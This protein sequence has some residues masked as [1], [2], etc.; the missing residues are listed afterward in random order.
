MQKIL[1][2]RGDWLW[3]GA[4]TASAPFFIFPSRGSIWIFA[5]VLVLIIAR[6]A[7][8]R[9][10]FDRTPLDWSICILFLQVFATCFVVPEIG[11][12]VPKVTGALYGVLYY[13]ALVKVIDSEKAL[14]TALS[15]YLAL[16]VG[17]A[18]IGFLGMIWYNEPRLA[19]ATAQ[20]PNNSPFV[21]WNLPGAEAGFNPNPLGGI[22]L[23]IVPLAAI[24]WIQPGKNKGR[25]VRP[26]GGL[27]RSCDCDL[28]HEIVWSMALAFTRAGICG[29]HLEMDTS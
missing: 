7:S 14:K 21:H 15:G 23:L 10:P 11:F 8:K 3:L 17:V 26:G 19:A 6:L 13:Y 1:A 16:G 25:M 24:L 28:F 4:L 22:L 29:V 2:G 20:N 27:F 5:A 9:Y 18:I 12:S